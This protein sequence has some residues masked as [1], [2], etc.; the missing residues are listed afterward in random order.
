MSVILIL[1]KSY[2]QKHCKT[3]RQIEI[4][5]LMN[6]ADE[7]GLG[8]RISKSRFCSRPQ[9]TLKPRIVAQHVFQS[10]LV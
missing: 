2:Y 4:C 5:P 8:S 9:R 3:L 6:A 1:I 7:Y 10:N